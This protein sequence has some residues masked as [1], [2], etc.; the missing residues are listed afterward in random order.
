M[1]VGVQYQ[2][3]QDASFALWRRALDQ[4]APISSATRRT[5]H[6]DE[7]YNACVIRLQF[8]LLLLER[9]VSSVKIARREERLYDR[10]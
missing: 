5:S 3:V 9:Y 2:N 8:F 7:V 4:T 6:V 10:F 1:H